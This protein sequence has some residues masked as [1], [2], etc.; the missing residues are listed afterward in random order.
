[1]T[2]RTNVAITPV[3]VSGSVQAIVECECGETFSMHL[4]DDLIDA[5]TKIQNDVVTKRLGQT[6]A[7]RTP[8]ERV[9]L[10]QALGACHD[11]TLWI[12]THARNHTEQRRLDA[13][14]GTEY[15]H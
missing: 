13:S 2:E 3:S 6:P 5:M 9:L 12:L 10:L 8:E 11:F 1:M 4:D 15:V 14:K 7:P